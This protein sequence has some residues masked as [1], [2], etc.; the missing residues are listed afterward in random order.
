MTPSVTRRAATADDDAFLFELFKAVRLP[1]FAQAPLDQAQLDLLIGIQFTGQ[2]QS[3][4]AQY[5]GGHDIVLLE[6]KPIGRIWLYRA[7]AEHHLVDISMLPE[8]R[9]RGIGAAL[10]AEVIAT[11]R[12]AGVRLTCSVAVTNAGSLRFHQ[13]LGFQIVG[14]DEVYYDLA[15]ER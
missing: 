2:Q 12:T 5:P 1:E 9:N 8:F 6:G 10:V 4:A 11:A 13:R 15:V 14:Q 3:Y 7:A